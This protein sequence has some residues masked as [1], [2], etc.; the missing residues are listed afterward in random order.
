VLHGQ[1]KVEPLEDVEV[2][3]GM[4]LL[5][6][7]EPALTSAEVVAKGG[8][9]RTLDLVDRVGRRAGV[10]DMGA[11]AATVQDPGGTSSED[12]CTEVLKLET[13]AMRSP[14]ASTEADKVGEGLRGDVVD[15]AVAALAPLSWPGRECRLGSILDTCPLE[16]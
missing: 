1:R 11:T 8:L 16:G 12:G 10:E 6:L 7:W 3:V 2:A 9:D 14:P 5:V 15:R 13:G 4:A